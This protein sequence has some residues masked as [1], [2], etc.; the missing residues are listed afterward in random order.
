MVAFEVLFGKEAVVLQKNKLYCTEAKITGPDS[1]GGNNGD[2][3]VVC[4]GV[5]FTF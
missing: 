3:T 5:R 1:T 2:S 4:S